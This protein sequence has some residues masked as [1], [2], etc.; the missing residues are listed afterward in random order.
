MCREC[1]LRTI[2]PGPHEYEKQI[3][4]LFGMDGFAKT[5]KRTKML[6]F[7]EE[8]MVIAA[9]MAVLDQLL[10]LFRT[11]NVKRVD[12][13]AMLTQTNAAWTAGVLY[14]HLVKEHEMM[15]AYRKTG[16]EKGGA[17]NES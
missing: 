3:G 17:H 13:K 14:K 16:A 1:G 11:R 8:M 12:L 6:P 10:G 9:D 5:G 4:A 2:L 7:S 15:Q